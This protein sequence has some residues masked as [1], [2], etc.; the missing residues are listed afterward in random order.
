MTNELRY[1]FH[2]CR[3]LDSIFNL[4]VE[5]L[6][7]TPTDCIAFAQDG[8]FIGGHL[9]TFGKKIKFTRKV[10]NSFFCKTDA[11]FSFVGKLNEDLTTSVVNG[12]RGGIFFTSTMA[13]LK[14]TATQ[15]AEGGL[16]DIYLSFGTYTKSFYSVMYA[17]SCIKVKLLNT[18]HKRLHHSV[19]WGNAVPK[20]IKASVRK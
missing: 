5:F 8:D 13:S 9:G 18:K 17:P 12:G 10:M 19:S 11:P 1:S 7:S 15:Q 20:I 4:M 3:N 2:I 14:Q 16:T 6:S